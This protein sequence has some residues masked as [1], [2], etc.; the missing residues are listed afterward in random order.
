MSRVLKYWPLA[1]IAFIAPFGL[2]AEPLLANI[3][4]NISAPGVW[5]YTVFNDELSGSSNYI[6]SFSL[7][8]N[9]PVTVTGTPD[10]WS[11]DTDNLTFVFWLNADPVLPYPHD[12]APDS[13]LTGFSISSLSAVSA[14]DSATMASWDHTLDVP[15]PVSNALT[16]DSPA[17]P[18][19]VP[20]PRFIF[21]VSSGI[22]VLSRVKRRG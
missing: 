1:L 11:V 5:A 4:A 17:L 7:L 13:F 21:S 3:D 8:I 20:E 18:A 10:G 22:L 12:I 9:A 15:G 14:F 6:D 2:K 16:V 19:T